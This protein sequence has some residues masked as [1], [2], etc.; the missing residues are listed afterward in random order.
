MEDST[1]ELPEQNTGMSGTLNVH[2]LLDS[3][4]ASEKTH[5]FYRTLSLRP[6]ASSPS[7]IKN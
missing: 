1:S 5:K 4:T 3:N 6:P 2:L 7:G